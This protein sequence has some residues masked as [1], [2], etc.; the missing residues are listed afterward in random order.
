VSLAAASDRVSRPSGGWREGLSARPVGTWSWYTAA[1]SLIFAANVMFS[2][3][4]FADSVFDLYAGRYIVRHRWVPH[5][6]VFTSEAH[7]AGWV[8]QQW[9]A[10]VLYY[11]AWA[12]GGY[13]LLALFSAVLVTSGFALLALLML[14]RGVPATRMF[15]WTLAAF[16]VCMGNTGIRAQSFGYPCLAVTLWLILEDDRADRLRARTWLVIPVLVLWANTHG[17]VLLGS[18]LVVLYA[19]YRATR[20][21]ARGESR[22]LPAC[23]GLAA[24]AAAAVLCTP[25]GTGVIWYYSRF[26]GNPVLASNIVEWSRPTPLDPF[27]WAFFALVLATAVAVAVGWRR[28]VRPDPLLLG[29]ALVL[30]ALALTAVRNQAWFAFGGSL[31]A[32]DTL[33]RGRRGQVSAL[34]RTFRQAL[35]GLLATMAL[36]SL[37]VLAVTPTSQF[38]SEMPR[39]AIGVAAAMA[40]RHPALRVLGDDWSG[41]PMLWLHPATLGRVGFDIRLEQ[42][43]T[44]QLSAYIDFLFVHPGWQRVLRGYGIVVVSRREHPQLAADLERAHAWRIVYRDRDG[45]VLERRGIA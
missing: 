43:S 36:V 15:A 28:G 23:F 29:V 38:E 11:G 12:A 5:Q 1:V 18:A 41:T 34:G 4:L 31:L 30:L 19:G 7:R 14:R 44:G 39:Q 10:H 35:A 42:Y 32:A 17:S 22:E 20:A 16:A 40:A 2:R 3:Y 37:G 33:A 13:R 21:L 25:Y 6:N 8:D 26:A 9:L 24:A 45:L 27:S